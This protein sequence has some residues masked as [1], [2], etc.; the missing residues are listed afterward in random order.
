MNDNVYILIPAFN[1]ENKIKDV[2]QDL[3]NSFENIVVVND[4]STD[5]T[6]DILDSLNVIHIKH[7]LNLGQG[8]A[9]STGLK[10]IKKID[11]A[12]AV[13]TFDADGQ[14]LVSDA[15]TF[16]NEILRCDEE[17][18]FGS[19][20]LEDRSNISLIKRIVLKIVVF[21]TRKLSNIN[22]TD[23]HNGLKAYKTSCLN[24][25]KITIDGFGFESQII[26]EVS[27]KNIKYKEMPVTIMYSDY[28]KAKGQKLSNGLIILE[29]LFKS[30]N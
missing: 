17:I 3:K 19:R 20:F 24:N 12:E 4:G 8:A 7:I 11:N 9:I 15:K 18:I 2:V 5:L 13:I 6:G 28:S 10:W 29:D 26:N 16:A 23:V 14:H 22:L 25:I 30:K 27:K 21:F 1:E